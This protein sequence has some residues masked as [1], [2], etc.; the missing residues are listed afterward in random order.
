MNG[1]I[2][3]LAEGITLYLGDCREILPTLGAVDAVVTDPPYSDYVHSKSRR[4]GADG[5]DRDGYLASYSRA[6]DLG[7]AAITEE[8][9]K[10]CAEQFARVSRR[11]ILI[12]SDLESAHLWRLCCEGAGLDYC[13]TGLWHKQN[14]TPQFT[15]DRPAVAAEAITI[16]HPCG[17]KTWNGGGPTRLLVRP[18]S[19]QSVVGRTAASHDTEAGSA[20][21]CLSQRFYRSWT[22]G[23]RS[24]HGVRHDR[25]R[26]YSARSQVHRGRERFNIF[27]CCLP[28]TRRGAPLARH[29]CRAAQARKAS[30]ARPMM[31]DLTEVGAR[32]SA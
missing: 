17:R 25:C 11:W 30:G 12:F 1:R 27:R 19:H 14:A 2:E 32:T 9:R 4:G 8:T 6:K 22:D 26:L 10:L 13:R 23:A 21:V 20:D 5:L 15:G 16:V 31:K 18:D 28:A 29:V 24:L 3:H 7:F